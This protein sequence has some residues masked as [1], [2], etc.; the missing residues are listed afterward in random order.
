MITPTRA[1]TAIMVR[2][3]MTAHVPFQFHNM[4]I[5]VAAAAAAAAAVAHDKKNART[6]PVLEK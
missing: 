4:S 6:K 1:R 2:R 5:A 3:D